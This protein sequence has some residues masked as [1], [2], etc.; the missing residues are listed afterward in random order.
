[1]RNILFLLLVLTTSTFAQEVE[2]GSVFIIQFNDL[3]K[4]ME[5]ELVNKSSLKQLDDISSLDMILN[6]KPKE[7]QIIGVFT[8]GVTGSSANSVLVLISGL[9]NKLDFDLEMKLP[10]KWRFQETTTS[11]LYHDVMSLQFWSYKVDKILFK[12]FRVL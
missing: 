1:M 11:P 8:K 12:E 9:K 2:I 3:E 4:G 10:R 5:F 6:I 7:N